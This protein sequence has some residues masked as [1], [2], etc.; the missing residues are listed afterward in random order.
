MVPIPYNDDDG[1]VVPEGVGDIPHIAVSG[2][3]EHCS[4]F[5]FPPSVRPPSSVTGV[6]Y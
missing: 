3:T 1:E 5:H 2:P 6:T 4:I